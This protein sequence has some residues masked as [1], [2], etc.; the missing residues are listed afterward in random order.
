MKAVT[1]QNPL[2]TA[3]PLT[4]DQEF[5]I[6]S[7]FLLKRTKDMVNKY[8]Q[9]LVKE[10]QVRPRPHPTGAFFSRDRG[11]LWSAAGES[12]GRDGDA[13]AALPPGRAMRLGRGQTA[14]SE[15]PRSVRHTVGGECG[16]AGAGAGF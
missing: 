15:R 4:V 3:S 13:G 5:D 16:G 8:R 12:V 2:M 14:S 11:Y 6:V 7:S 10:A 1:E 9:L